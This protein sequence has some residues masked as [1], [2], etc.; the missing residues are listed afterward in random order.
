MK[1]VLKENKK[2]KEYCK[3]I[4]VNELLK[5]VICPNLNV[6]SE[7]DLNKYQGVP[8][9][10][11]HPNKQELMQELVEKIN[12]I[13]ENKPFF[14]TDMEAGPGTA[15]DGATKFSSLRGAAETKS[16]DLCYNMGLSASYEGRKAGFNWTFGPV[17][18]ILG[19]VNSPIMSLRSAGESKE[20][21]LKYAYAY[22]QGIEDGGM[23]ATIKHFPGDGFCEYDQHLTTAI[24]PLS[25][26][27]WDQS[28]GEV[29]KYFIDNGVKAIMPGHIALPCYDKI[30]K[31]TNIYPPATLSSNLLTGLLKEKLGFEGLIISDAI[32]MGGFA[33][34]MNIYKAAARFL[35]SG[36]DTLLFMHPSDEYFQEMNKLINSG[37]LDIAV[38]R[39]RAYRNL[40]FLED[41]QKVIKLKEVNSQLISNKIIENSV[42]IF[43]DKV[44]I[45]PL[46][47]NKKILHVNITTQIDD[48]IIDSFNDS[49]KEYGD[50]TYLKDPGCDKLVEISKRGIYDYI[51]C[52]VGNKHGYGTNRILLSGYQARNMMGGWT[53]FN[54]PV[55]FVCFM[56]PYIHLEYQAIID[57]LIYTYGHTE[58]TN[59]VVC[60]LL[61]NK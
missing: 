19:N 5:L 6:L 39:N 27:K 43:K 13:N 46:K 29:F 47:I 26:E 15:L 38:L 28:F 24:N 50:I 35:M 41:N 8:F 54:T 14:V 52:S 11:I 49:L 16:V 9:I 1:Y 56:H 7:Y 57:T 30:D 42:K 55:V 2:I 22:Y 12:Q 48:Y 18:D 25:K 34:Y 61:F 60:N 58:Y 40:L 44:N 59:K 37:Y 20:D 23:I 51:I 4:S 21:I 17:V 10:F 36:G 3:N 53:K 31:E 32:N 45:L 33:G